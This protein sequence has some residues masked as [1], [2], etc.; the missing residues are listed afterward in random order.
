MASVLRK[1]CEA[2]N[3]IA[4]ESFDEL[5]LLELLKD[6]DAKKYTEK[7]R[8]ARY[9]T[10]HSS[11]KRPLRKIKAKDYIANICGGKI[12]KA[13]PEWVEGRNE[14]V[15]LMQVVVTGVKNGLQDYRWIL[16]KNK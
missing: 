5:Q 7:Q 9:E 10:E 8:K 15:K 14:K 6:D 2:R 13:R 11:K 3:M 16:E 12:A 1:E 4:P